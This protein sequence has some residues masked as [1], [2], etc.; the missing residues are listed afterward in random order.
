MPFDIKTLL[1]LLLLSSIFCAALSIIYYSFKN[2]IT[3]TP[4]SLIVGQTLIKEL[5]SMDKGSIV[6]LGSGFGNLLNLAAKKYPQLLI[7]GIENSWVPY[8]ISKI[9]TLHHKN[10]KIIRQDFFKKKLD[11]PN[12][13][14]CFLSPAIMDKL[15][16]KIHQEHLDQTYLISHTFAFKEITFEK[17]IVCSDLYQ[18]PIYFYKF[19]SG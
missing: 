19:T 4:T 18:T 7:I 12:L 6:V 17:R 15:K 16:I 13:I 9:I 3:P 2:G 1:S 11:N 8:L 5:P 10:C 14:L